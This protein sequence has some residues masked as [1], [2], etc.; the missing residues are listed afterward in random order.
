M[1]FSKA[2]AH[3]LRNYVGFSGRASRSE[4]WYFILFVHL[5][6]IAAGPV[7]FF[8]F[9]PVINRGGSWDWPLSYA[10]MVATLPPVVAVTTRRLHDLNRSGW[11]QLLCLTMVGII[12]LLIWEAQPG[13][14]GSNRFGPD[15]LGDPANRPASRP[16]PAIVTYAILPLAGVLFA[17]FVSLSI[18]LELG[19]ILSERVITGDEL[20]ERDKRA[21]IESKVLHPEESIAFFYGDGAFSV[22][23]G[24]QFVTADR[25]VSYLP[26]NEG[27]L[28]RYEMPFRN[29]ASVELIEAHALAGLNT[30]H[31]HGSPGAAYQYIEIQ[32]STAG[33]GHELFLQHLKDRLE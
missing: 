3:C 22:A 12:P 26:D 19:Y 10:I 24:G 31:V 18:A 6:S 9:G 27:Q 28:Q 16:P 30:Y 11:W 17:A 13:T 23:A 2:V 7:D 8:V 33:D 20:S 14:A 29:I 25:L 5:I 4:F 21:L 15:P 32:L 1:T